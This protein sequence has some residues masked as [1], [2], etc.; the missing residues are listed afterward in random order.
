MKAWSSL[1]AVGACLA[2]F[3]AAVWRAPTAFRQLDNNGAIYVH[4]DALK[5]SLRPAYGTGIDPAVLIRARALIPARDT[6]AVIRGPG[7]P[8]ATANTLA[9]IA[10]FAGYW[11]LPRRQVTPA[12]GTRP[13]WVLSYGGDLASLHYRYV[14]LVRAGPGLE[15][16]QVAR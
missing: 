8:N 11:L 13:N 1:R 5:R 14:R 9:A 7:A 16:A 2:A 6:Y 12:P 15:L 4:E 10:P 3:A